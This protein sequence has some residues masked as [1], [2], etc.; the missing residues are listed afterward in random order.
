[1][2]ST[3][4]RTFSF[5]FPEC[6]FYVSLLLGHHHKLLDSASRPVDRF[7][8]WRHRKFHPLCSNIIM[9]MQIARLTEPKRIS[10]QV[11]KW[12]FNQKALSPF[13]SMLNNKGSCKEERLRREKKILKDDVAL[14]RRKWNFQLGKEKLCSASVQHKT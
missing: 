8:W 7:L 5:N 11:E 12:I 3:V 4:Y 13:C 1:M 6:K 2:S 10:L 9:I 14:E